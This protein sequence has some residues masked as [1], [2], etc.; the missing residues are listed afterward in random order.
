MKTTK[1]FRCIECEATWTFPLELNRWKPK[2]IEKYGLDAVMVHLERA[3][4][5]Y[6]KKNAYQHRLVPYE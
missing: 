2:D 5:R 6:G 4:S 1:G 3:H